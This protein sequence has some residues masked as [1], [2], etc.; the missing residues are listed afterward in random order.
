VGFTQRQTALHI[1]QALT[2]QAQ[3][4]EFLLHGSLNKWQPSRILILVIM[5]VITMVTWMGFISF[6][7]A[8]AGKPAEV[9]EQFGRINGIPPLLLY[10][11]EKGSAYIL[12]RLSFFT[13]ILQ[14]LA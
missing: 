8:E 9:P 12:V 4:A 7:Q 6:L 14:R 3:I 1:M 11:T 2:E 13:Q 10:K 5:I